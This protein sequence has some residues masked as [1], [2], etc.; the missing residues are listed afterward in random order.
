M[1][2]RETIE[3]SQVQHVI[4]LNEILVFILPLR[5]PPLLS[6]PLMASVIDLTGASKLLVYQAPA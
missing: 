5:K 6:S 1:M 2:T 4:S 3:A